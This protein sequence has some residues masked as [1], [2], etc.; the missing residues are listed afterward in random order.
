MAMCDPDMIQLERKQGLML[1]LQASATDAYSSVQAVSSVCELH[2]DKVDEAPE[3]EV[4]M[5]HRCLT[6]EEQPN[7]FYSMRGFH[8]L[9]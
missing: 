7:D 3:A 9:P 5:I 1:I 6:L 8:M 4:D 2:R